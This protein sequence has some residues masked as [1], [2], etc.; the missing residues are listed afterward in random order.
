MKARV[1]GGMMAKKGNVIVGL[2][3]GTTKT[4]AIV[5]EV[6]EMGLDIIGIGMHP[7]E[8][9]RKGVVVN[10]ESTV[11]AIRKATDEAERMSGCEIR[12]VY[13]GIAGAHIKGQNSL[14]I[15]AVKGREV[16]YEDV[17]ACR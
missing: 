7:S 14:G 5:G 3:I 17:A 8:G 11:D 13:A 10:I 4:C 12:S 6:T 9:L 15:I 2:D 16:N 1:S